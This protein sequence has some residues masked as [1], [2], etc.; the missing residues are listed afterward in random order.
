[1]VQLA[2]DFLFVYGMM[3]VGAWLEGIGGQET[4]ADQFFTPLPMGV[5]GT[6]LALY[7][8]VTS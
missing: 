6:S 8:W 4:W 7:N 3:V 1:M 5:S 2:V